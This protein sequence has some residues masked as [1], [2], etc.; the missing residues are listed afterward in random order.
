MSPAHMTSVAARRATRH[1]RWRRA[2]AIIAAA[3]VLP[4]TWPGPAGAVEY[5]GNGQGTPNPAYPSARVVASAAAFLAQRAGITAFAVIDDKGALSGVRVHQRFFSA[6][7]VKAML[8]VAYLRGLS[9]Q[10]RGLDPTA[11]GLLYPMIHV[12][13]N[14]AAQAVFEIVGQPGLQ[15]LARAVGMTD[16]ASSASWGFTQ[17]S[18]AD[19]SRFFY[20][21]DRL[22]PPR[23]DAYARGLLSGITADQAWGIPAAA[24]PRFRVFFKG[25]WLPG[26]GLVSQASRLEGLRGTFALAVLTA[27]G[28]SMFYGEQTIEG[29]AARVIA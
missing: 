22:I 26:R 4:V 11:R 27:G 8:L 20:L 19:Q 10:N 7:V 21:L 25:G 14:V 3:S 6:S 12:S 2:A 18:A 24:R 28:P 15:S 29:V 23:F 16:F 9:A 13:D 5:Q 1:P 17:I